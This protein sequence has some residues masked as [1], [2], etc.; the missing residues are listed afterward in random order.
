M[1][2]KTELVI[3]TQCFDLLAWLLP[4]AERFPKAQRFVLTQRLLA[5]ALDFQ[6][7]LYDANASQGAARL[8]LLLAADAHLDK[9]RLYLRLA[10]RF[11]WL[12]SGPYEHAS[13][14][15]AGVGRLLGGWLRQTRAA[16]KGDDA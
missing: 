14:M 1:A 13:R 16:A 3:F 11:G 8:R 2:E 15:V 7:V 10:H 5:A 12:A 4:Q 9:L 6:E